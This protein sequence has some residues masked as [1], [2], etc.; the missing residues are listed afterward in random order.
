[1]S[2]TRLDNVEGPKETEFGNEGIRTY[3]IATIL[4]YIGA[5]ALMFLV[6]LFFLGGNS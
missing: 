4:A 1:M 6:A 5:G 2:T 3:G